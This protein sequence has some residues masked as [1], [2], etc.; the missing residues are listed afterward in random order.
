MS[1]RYEIKQRIIGFNRR[2]LAIALMLCKDKPYFYYS[3][4]GFVMNRFK[5]RTAALKAWNFDNSV[6]SDGQWSSLIPGI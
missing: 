3:N 4:E 6:E 5:T 2:G 1:Q